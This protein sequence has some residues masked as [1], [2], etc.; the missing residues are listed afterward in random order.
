MH[1]ALG[2]YGW[3]VFLMTYSA[4]GVCQLCTKIRCGC[5]PCVDRPKTNATIIEDNCCQC[6]YAALQSM[7]EDGDVEITYATFHVDVGETPFYVAV[8]YA[9]KKIVISI[10]GTLSMKVNINKKT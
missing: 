8:D 9:R 3:P 1:F 6:N 2:A 4:T 7:V 5:I 10:R